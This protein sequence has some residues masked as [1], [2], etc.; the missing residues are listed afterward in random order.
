LRRAYVIQRLRRVSRNAYPEAASNQVAQCP[1][2]AGDVQTGQ[3]CAPH[4]VLRGHGMAEH[5]KQPIA[6]R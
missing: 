5:C 4:V 2:V 6:F 3:H 1:H